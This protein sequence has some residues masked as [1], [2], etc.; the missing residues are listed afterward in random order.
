MSK[1]TLQQ[2][3][4]HIKKEFAKMYNLNRTQ[5]GAV[6]EQ[7]RKDKNLSR[8][9]VHKLTE[10]RIS[11][12]RVRELESGRQ[13]PPTE[14]EIQILNEVYGTAIKFI[15]FEHKTP[16]QEFEENM[17]KIQR[18]YKIQKAKEYIWI[19]V[20]ETQSS[21][22]D[23]TIETGKTFKMRIPADEL[24]QVKKRLGNKFKGIV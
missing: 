24:E 15:Q 19:R 8:K 4:N 7:A 2:Q 10:G 21:V 16:Q 12:S 5:Y 13:R 17:M 23:A 14:E 6:L 1:P 3:L 18:P 22:V 11:W 9:D 20:Q